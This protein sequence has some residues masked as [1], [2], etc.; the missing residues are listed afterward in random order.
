MPV[1]A[2]AA[3][4]ST[5]ERAG[6]VR[7][8][9]AID[10]S[11]LGGAAEGVKERIRVRGEALLRNHDVL[12]ARGASDPVIAIEVEPLGSEPGYRCMFAL[13][14]DDATIGDTEGTSLC[15]LCT[16]DELVEHLMAAIE[17]VVP[18]VPASS[19]RSTDTTTSSRGRDV[20]PPSARTPE[21]RALGKGGLA[22]AIT[23]SVGV[24]V[25]VGL[26]V[27]DV[28]GDGD[29]GL[30]I[31]GIAIASISVGL[32]IAGLTMVAIDLRRGHAERATQASAR[33]SRRASLRGSRGR[34][35]WRLS[36]TAGRT[37]AGMAVGGRF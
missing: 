17:R 28:P 31:G 20:P 6:V 2:G 37:G 10:T 5:T 34:A 3:P 18:Q 9:L 25:G 13:R 15:Q 27:R 30:R 14:R 16:E 23:G 11:A 12:P 19:G 33:L 8:S 1:P 21:L 35:T 32:L 7:A 26:A 36:P 4:A 22:A 29:R 24:G